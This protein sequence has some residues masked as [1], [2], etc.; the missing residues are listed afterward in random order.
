MGKVIHAEDKFSKSKIK[1]LPPIYKSALRD[2]VRRGSKTPPSMRGVFD[3]LEDAMEKCV[4]HVGDAI[5][6]R[7]CST[8]IYYLGGNKFCKGFIDDEE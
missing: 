2:L 3:S 1:L 8:P 5:F 7:N 4:L 6:L